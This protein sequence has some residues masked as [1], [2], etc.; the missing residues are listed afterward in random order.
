MVG[1]PQASV[2]THKWINSS[3]LRMSDAGFPLGLKS[4]IALEPEAGYD[5]EIASNEGIDR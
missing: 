5:R 1:V 3:T 4:R 2:N